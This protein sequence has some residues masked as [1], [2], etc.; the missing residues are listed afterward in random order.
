MQSRHFESVG[1]QG[2]P[3]IAKAQN[4]YGPQRFPTIFLSYAPIF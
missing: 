3:N 2:G 1:A 4:L